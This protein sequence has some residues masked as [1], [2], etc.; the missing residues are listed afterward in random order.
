MHQEIVFVADIVVALVVKLNDLSYQDQQRFPDHHSLLL[1]QSHAAQ[2]TSGASPSSICPLGRRTSSRLGRSNTRTA[3]SCTT[4]PPAERYRRVATSSIAY[5]VIL[6]ALKTANELP[7]RQHKQPICQLRAKN[8]RRLC[9]VAVGIAI[10]LAAAVLDLQGHGSV[11][12]RSI[13][14]FDLGT[15]HQIQLA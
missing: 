9:L 13:D 1:R 14:Q 2:P 15:G 4:I 7:G 3:P 6:I 10:G 12:G 11:E 8:L 5:L